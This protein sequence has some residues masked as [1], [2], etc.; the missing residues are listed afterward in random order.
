MSPVPLF[1]LAFAQLRSRR[2]AQQRQ[3]GGTCDR[4][5]GPGGSVVRAPDRPFIPPGA[6]LLLFHRLY[7]FLCTR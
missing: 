1:G 4:A 7:T 3:I 5:R 6:Y 2:V